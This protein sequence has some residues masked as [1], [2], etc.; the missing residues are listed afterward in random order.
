MPHA[1]MR[2]ALVALFVLSLVG[3]LAPRIA[4]A[5]EGNATLTVHSR[6]CPPGFSGATD[7]FETCHDNPGIQGI[8]F[9]VQGPR[10]DAGLPDAEGNIIFAN[11]P[12]GTYTLFNG[13]PTDNQRPYVYCSAGDGS[14]G[15]QID[16]E[17]TDYDGYVATIALAEGQALICDWYTIPDADLNTQLAN[18]T[19]HNRW[20]PVGYDGSDE[21]NVCHGNVGIEFV[22]FTAKGPTN[23]S[24]L[25][26]DGNIAFS[27]LKPGLYTIDDDIGLDAHVVCSLFSTPE[28]PFLE[29]WV[30]ADDTLN[31]SIDPGDDVICDWYTYPTEAFYRGGSS[32]PI[33]VIAC[34]TDPGGLG[35]GMGGLPAGC[36]G[37]SGVKVTVFPTLAGTGYAESCLTVALGGCKVV[38]PYRIPLTATI[39]ESTLPK[40]WYPKQNPLTGSQYTEFASFYFL[41]LPDPKGD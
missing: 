37:V 30:T 9:Q 38:V 29:E 40:G 41:L 1:R 35:P 33:A 34:Q 39:D 3:S 17:L 25:I 28:S 2:L 15:Q 32:L 24:D 11:L 4:S 13:L 21:F 31:F 14:D 22:N 10:W 20:C 26:H 23:R 19:I 7:I 8:E 12:A 18:I 5:Q 27:W 36:K 16:T 6:F